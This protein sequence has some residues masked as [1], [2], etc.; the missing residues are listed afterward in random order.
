MPHNPLQDPTEALR[1]IVEFAQTDIK[2][3]GIDLLTTRGLRF[4]APS[5]E[6]LWE[7]AD[8]DARPLTEKLLDLQSELRDFIAR[9]AA[10]PSTDVLKVPFSDLRLRLTRD[11]KGDVH[12]E[13]T[14][15]L[16]DVF[17]YR[18][19]QL[20]EIVGTNK[21]GI[22][23]APMPRDPAR[24]CGHVFVRVT[25]K[26]YCSTKCQSRTYMRGQRQEEKKGR[27]YGKTSR[28]R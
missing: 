16:R 2:G 5:F 12:I 4:L 19:V 3:E 13:A 18:T 17:L 28:P 10:L 21:L 7:I 23:Q 20:L 8:D 26:E 27:R 9:I 14:G 6:A 24:R 22:C 15:H 11:R 25:Q 1:F